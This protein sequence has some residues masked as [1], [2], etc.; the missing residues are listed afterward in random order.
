MTL[1]EVRPRSALPPAASLLS[2]SLSL[3]FPVLLPHAT[4]H[5]PPAGFSFSCDCD[6]H[7]IC[8]CSDSFSYLPHATGDFSIV[9]LPLSAY[10]PLSSP[11]SLC[12]PLSLLKLC[13]CKGN[14]IKEVIPVANLTHT[15]RF[16]HAT[17]PSLWHQVTFCGCHSLLSLSLPLCLSP[18]LTRIVGWPKISIN[19]P[20]NCSFFYNWAEHICW[21]AAY[22]SMLKKMM[23]FLKHPLAS[24]ERE[25]KVGIK[26]ERESCMGSQWV[27]RKFR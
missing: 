20:Q 18:R 27:E 23:Q 21:I 15:L 24:C 19:L 25:G 11:S 12:L 22:W 8:S 13:V 9:Q 3:S 1:S 7:A 2:L 16:L 14:D 4:C 17:S 6:F 5:L 10:L 26:R